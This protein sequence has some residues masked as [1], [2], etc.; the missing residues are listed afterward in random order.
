MKIKIQSISDI[1]TNSST[2][3]FTVYNTSNKQDIKDVV[4]A[5]L[6]IDGNHTFDDFFNI[7]MIFYDYAV[8]ELWDNFENL[9]NEFASF[10]LFQEHLEH[11]TDEQ[12]VQYEQMWEDIRSYESAFPL[13]DGYYVELKEGVEATD[14][15]HAAMRAIRNLDRLFDHDYTWG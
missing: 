3:V 2:E 15:M 13:Y 6:A 8:G 11:L 9:H 4:N 1:I 7:G 10:E 12:L 5:I 14:K